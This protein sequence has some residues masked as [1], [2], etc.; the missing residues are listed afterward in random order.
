M[1]NE[2]EAV[3]PYARALVQAATDMGCLGRV[4]E[5]MDALEA[6]WEGS[7]TFRDWAHAFHSLPR[8]EHRKQ[9]DAV[10][11]ETMAP[12]TLV[13]LEAL[14]VNGLMSAVPNVIKSFRR[15]ADKAEGRLDVALVFAAPPTPATEAGLRE[16]ALA[17]YGAK[18]RVT[19]TVDPR[20]RRPGGAR[21]PHPNRRF[22]GGASA[23]SAPSLCTLRMI[24]DE[25]PIETR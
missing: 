12:P 23:S 4:R 17:A 9:I 16:K 2:E 7:K 8:A 24:I 1:V 10:W 13:L 25:D 11:G 20:R 19:V 14:S 21:G 3:R 22:P 15:F 6:Q 18:T 5:N